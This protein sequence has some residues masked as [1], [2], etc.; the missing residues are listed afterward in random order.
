MSQANRSCSVDADGNTPENCFFL[1]EEWGDRFIGRDTEITPL[2]PLD[3]RDRL[4]LPPP[5]WSG[6]AGEGEY[7]VRSLKGMRK[8]KAE[9]IDEQARGFDV[10]TVS[11]VQS[12]VGSVMVPPRP[13]ARMARTAVLNNVVA[14]IF[15]FKLKF[16][17]GR[18][19]MCCPNV[20]PMYPRGHE[21]YPAHPAYPSGHSTQAHAIAYFYARLFPQ[22][23]DD[24]MTAAGAI[25]KNREIAG[26]HYPSD[27][28]AG[29]LLAR[30][31]VD[32]LLQRQRFHALACEVVR[33][34]PEHEPAFEFKEVPD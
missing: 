32:Y 31:V 19:F 6:T 18:P 26:L 23:M 12:V 13:H 30:E 2:L 22:L 9:E 14:P 17:R 15:Y 5:P 7:L 27:S 11:S 29:K 34:F 28:L 10:Q 24:L 8:E 1:D 20:E 33:E 4:V 3:W 25:A 21:F 16:K